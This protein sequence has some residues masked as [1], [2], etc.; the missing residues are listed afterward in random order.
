MY[1]A[2]RVWYGLL[3]SGTIIKEF[4]RE[5]EKLKTVLNDDM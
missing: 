1:S 3:S 4:K 2:R 5:S